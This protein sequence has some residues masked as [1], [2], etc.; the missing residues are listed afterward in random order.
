[1][2]TKGS[3][4][5]NAISP[6]RDATGDFVDGG[7]VRVEARMQLPKGGPTGT[8][9]AFWLLPTIEVCVCVVKFIL[10]TSPEPYVTMCYFTET[11]AQLLQ[12]DR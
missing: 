4:P 12:N 5:G 11:L 3:S 9:S 2:T 1:M 10:T 8:W 6:P 7:R